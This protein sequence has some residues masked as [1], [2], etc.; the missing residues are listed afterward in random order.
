MTRNLTSITRTVVGVALSCGLVASFLVFSSGDASATSTL[1]LYVVAN[2]PGTTCRDDGMN[3]CSSIG[4]AVAIADAQANTAVTVNVAPGTYSENDAIDL[5]STDSLTIEGAGASATLVNGGG[6]GTVFSISGSGSVTLEGLTVENGLAQG[7]SGGDGN[8]GGIENAN[9]DLTLIS[10]VFSDDTT[11]GGAGTPGGSGIPGGAGG[12][13]SGG[14]LYDTNGDVT[15]MNSVFSDDVAT[16]GAGGSSPYGDAET[17]GVGGSAYGGA[18]FVQAGTLHVTGTSFSSDSAAGGTGGSGDFAGAG[19]DG[20]GGAVYCGQNVSTLTSDT[21]SS[22]VASGG[23]GGSSGY[24]PGSG[25]DA[26]GG[27]FFDAG[28]S[29][30]LTNATFF[31]DSANAGNGRSSLRYGGNGGSA[32]GG[33]VYSVADVMVVD[34]TIA[35]NVVT[36]GI[37]GYGIAYGDGSN[38]LMAGAG[39][40][41]AGGANIANSLFD[42]TDSCAGTFTD[43]LYNV[44]SDSSC[45]FLDDDATLNLA[46]SLAANGSSGPETLAIG[47]NSNAF[48]EVPTANCTILTDERGDARP[49]MTG[50][51]CDAGAYEYQGTVTYN[52]ETGSGVP[53]DTNQYFTGATVPV[54]FSPSPT[55]AGYDFAGWCDVATTPGTACSGDAYHQTGTTSF[56]MPAGDVTLYALWNAPVTLYVDE[57]G[58]TLTCLGEGTQAC[59][60]LADAIA[61]AQ[62][63]TATDVTIEVSA[64]TFPGGNVIDLPIS[65]TLSI[66]GAGSAATTVQ[67]NLSGFDFEV[68]QG[69]VAIEGL[70][71]ANAETSA[72]GG[73]DNGQGGGGG[74]VTALN[75]T[76]N[77][78]DATN[79]GAIY[80]NATLIAINDTFVDDHANVLGAAIFNNGELISTN[81]TFT[82]GTATDGAAIFISNNTTATLTNDTFYN[83]TATYGDELY[84][85]NGGSVTVANSILDDTQG[86][87]L[88]ENG[89]TITDGGNNVESDNSCDLAGSTSAS[90]INLASSLEAN[91]SN[92]P[93]TLAITPSSSAYQEV[94]LVDCT[95]TTDER[96]LSRPGVGT[97]SCDAGAYEY[98]YTPVHV[99][100]PTTTTP[101]DTLTFVSDGGSPV[102]NETGLGGSSVALPGAPSYAG[103]VFDGW[104]TQPTGGDLVGDAGANYTLNASLTLYAQWTKAV[105]PEL[106]FVTLGTIG[107]FAPGSSTLAKGLVDELK[108]LVE[109]LVS[110]RFSSIELIGEA[111]LPKTVTELRLARARAQ[112]VESYLQAHGL[113]HVTFVLKFQVTGNSL[114]DARVTVLGE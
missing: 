23:D 62:S 11:S 31:S 71:I 44:E 92:G 67:D 58:T 75:D 9:G 70:N 37:G 51:S 52:P 49:W 6:T 32:S 97:T 15:I 76:F 89:G 17:G 8:G 107:F 65:D 38:G 106:R 16:G 109:V 12:T 13:G 42:Q 55:L 100:S 110:G 28:T 113:S 20:N 93:D 24:Q 27:A 26:S 78:D 96:G 47:S 73:I 77:N 5:P 99:G 1:T 112:V 43:G 98:Q 30:S 80:N 53:S 84:V 59:P 21:F 90:S 35:D 7:T 57:S 69:T 104:Y 14:A 56:A 64:G 91:G 25:G 34:N 86:Y 3:A 105:T 79:G 45:G 22:D 66:D 72:G 60:T 18:L 85:L 50:Q 48:Q 2:A 95:P 114:T 88:C 41:S 87:G 36:A 94:P 29:A 81:S 83:D 68:T 63:Y 111:P 46:S 103:Y 74:V 82:G 39:I 10:D 4:D 40:D 61:V 101:T 19:G 102:A 33:A 108:T 54:L